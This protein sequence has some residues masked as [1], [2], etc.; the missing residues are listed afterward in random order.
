MIRIHTHTHTRTACARTLV[1]TFYLWRECAFTYC[2]KVKPEDLERG[3]AAHTVRT[4][5]DLSGE[6]E[7][8]A[9][10]ASTAGTGSSAKE[11]ALVH[12]LVKELKDNSLDQMRVTH[13]SRGLKLCGWC[14][15]RIHE[16]IFSLFVCIRWAPS[17]EFERLARDEVET[18]QISN[19]ASAFALHAAGD[20]IPLRCTRA[21]N[22]FSKDFVLHAPCEDSA[23]GE[24][25][26]EN[27]EEEM[28]ALSKWYTAEKRGA[29]VQ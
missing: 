3:S 15:Q 26:F 7:E 22:V 20:F 18:G 6:A 2:S 19:N 4:Y 17:P 9:G 16:E 23:I 14:Y 21:V 24:D 10:S 5:C 28:E 1:S 25:H 13:K 29:V 8:D 12:S 11:D 27:F